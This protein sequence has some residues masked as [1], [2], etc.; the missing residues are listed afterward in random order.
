MLTPSSA[1]SS[2]A[3]FLINLGIK[4][5]D[6]AQSVPE[7]PMPFLQRGK[8]ITP[9]AGGLDSYRVAVKKRLLVILSA[10]KNLAFLAAEIPHSAALRSE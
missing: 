5:V 9:S 3:G 2:D 6:P 7:D 8:L 10:A 1:L 4:C